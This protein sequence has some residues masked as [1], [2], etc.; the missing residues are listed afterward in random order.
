MLTSTRDVTKSTTHY[1]PVSGVLVIKSLL[2]WIWESNKDRGSTC[3]SASLS[4]TPP[5]GLTNFSGIPNTA[6]ARTSWGVGK[7]PSQWHTSLLTML[8]TIV[9][10]C[11]LPSITRKIF[12]I[13]Q[14]AVLSKT[15]GSSRP[16][17]RNE[18][19]VVNIPEEAEYRATSFEY[20]M[21]ALSP[22]QGIF[23]PGANLDS[24]KKPLIPTGTTTLEAVPT[25]STT[26]GT[27][28]SVN[29][30]LSEVIPTIDIAPSM[31]S[32]R[33]EDAIVELSYLLERW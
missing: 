16:V 33:E 7:A 29:L 32:Q 10:A 26:V 25:N 20:A 31:P 23:D 30:V 12:K 15:H 5:E 18:K 2:L 11:V 14:K 24:A 6:V 21:L 17:K 3:C 8:A 13:W 9:L 4:L 27:R 22:I 19:L 28:Q 1:P